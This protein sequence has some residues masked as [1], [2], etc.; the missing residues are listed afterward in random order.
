M[1]DPESAREKTYWQNWSDKFQIGFDIEMIKPADSYEGKKEY[2]RKYPD[3]PTWTI[4][5]ITSF[6]PLYNHTLTKITYNPTA[7]RFKF[8]Q[9]TQNGM[10]TVSNYVL[11]SSYKERYEVTASK[12]VCV[13]DNSGGTSFDSKSDP[14]EFNS[15]IESME[16]KIVVKPIDCEFFEV[17]NLLITNDNK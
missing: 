10:K 12:V 7:N 17:S 5:E 16:T 3:N 4:A 11:V 15:K 9:L 2:L 1:S 8:Y 6:Y 14:D 13:Q